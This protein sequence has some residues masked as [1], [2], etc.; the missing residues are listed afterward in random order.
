MVFDDRHQLICFFTCNIETTLAIQPSKALCNLSNDEEFSAED[1]EKLDKYEYEIKKL[2]CPIKIKNQVWVYINYSDTI[3]VYEKDGVK[4]IF[5][6]IWS[7]YWDQKEN[8]NLDD[9]ET[10]KMLVDAEENCPF[11]KTNKK[12]VFNLENDYIPTGIVNQF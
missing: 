9:E 5:R 10:Q 4:A 3:V 7:G 1:L 6:Y 12:T 8:L 2:S 11:I